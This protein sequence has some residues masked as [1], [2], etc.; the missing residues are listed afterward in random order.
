MKMKM[1][2]KVKMKVQ[3][4]EDDGGNHYA[5][6]QAQESVRGAETIWRTSG[7]GPSP[8]KQAVMKW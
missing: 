1:K 7:S 3:A 2:V 8:Y 6:A 5:D 4:P